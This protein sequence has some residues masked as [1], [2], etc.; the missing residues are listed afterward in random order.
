LVRC[1]DPLYG[2]YNIDVNIY[3]KFHKKY[4]DGT[5]KNG[6]EMKILNLIMVFY[7]KIMKKLQGWL[8]S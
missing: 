1:G 6:T 2:I 4:S 8:N 3:Q 5:C 7:A